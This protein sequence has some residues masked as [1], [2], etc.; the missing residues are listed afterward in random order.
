MERHDVAGLLEQLTGEGMLDSAGSFTLDSNRAWE[1]ARNLRFSDPGQYLPART[2][3]GFLKS[4]V[5]DTPAPLPRPL[6]GNRLAP[7]FIRVLELTVQ[8][9]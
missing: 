3:E 7:N 6:V 8:R 9:E 2:Q 4:G 5:G 1:K